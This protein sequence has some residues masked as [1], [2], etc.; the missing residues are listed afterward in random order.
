MDPEHNS[1]QSTAGQSVDI[2]E[3]ASTEENPHPNSL[4]AATPDPI[5][6]R[7]QNRPRPQKGFIIDA[8]PPSEYGTIKLHTEA[9]HWPRTDRRLF[10]TTRYQ[11]HNVDQSAASDS[12]IQRACS[13][14]DSKVSRYTGLAHDGLMF[15]ND[16]FHYA[17]H[18]FNSCLQAAVQ[19]VKEQFPTVNIDSTFTNHVVDDRE[20]ARVARR[21]TAARSR[22]PRQASRGST[23]A[24][25]RGIPSQSFIETLGPTYTDTIPYMRSQES[26]RLLNRNAS[27]QQGYD[28]GSYHEPESENSLQDVRV[29]RPIRSSRGLRDIFLMMNALS[30]DDEQ[31]YEVHIT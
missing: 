15:N 8:F 20:H 9:L 17:T 5:R 6:G 21:S 28:G 30:S 2:F 1:E 3:S 27:T 14:L 22:R 23:E 12:P 19:S 7:L 10:K 26:L 16:D 4:G 29:I 18:F 31:T 25:L 24:T 13:D 11:L